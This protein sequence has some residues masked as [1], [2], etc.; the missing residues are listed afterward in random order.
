MLLNP[1]VIETGCYSK[2]YKT[3]KRWAG[4]GRAEDTRA[5]DPDK[6]ITMLISCSHVK[7]YLDINCN[8]KNTVY[9]IMIIQ[10]SY[11]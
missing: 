6:Y 4:D 10:V 8:T 5:V 2:G 3:L 7:K 11:C 1:I 9:N